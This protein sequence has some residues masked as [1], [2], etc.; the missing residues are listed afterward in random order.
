MIFLK[1]ALIDFE[2][3]SLESHIL[4]RDFSKLE[5]IITLKITFEALQWPSRP[6]INLLKRKSLVSF[7]AQVAH[8]QE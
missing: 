3:K 1:V 2:N 4:Q 8:K 6:E 5:S 7:P